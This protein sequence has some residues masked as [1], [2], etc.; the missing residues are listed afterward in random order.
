MCWYNTLYLLSLI[1]L[2]LGFFWVVLG[3]AYYIILSHQPYKNINSTLYFY[4]D[5]IV[6][7]FLY[8]FI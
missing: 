2:L 8:I 7:T 6:Y 1:Y 4:I 5:I 3:F